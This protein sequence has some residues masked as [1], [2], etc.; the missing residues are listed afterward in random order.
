MTLLEEGKK[1]DRL[2]VRNGGERDKG[3]ERFE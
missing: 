3:V 1:K 2:P